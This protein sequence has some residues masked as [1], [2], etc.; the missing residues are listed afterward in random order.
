MFHLSQQCF[1]YS[2]C[3]DSSVVE[4]L[5][6]HHDNLVSSHCH[7]WLLL[8]VWAPHIYSSL[9]QKQASVRGGMLLLSQ[10]WCFML[11]RNEW[12]NKYLIWL[13]YCTNEGIWEDTGATQGPSI[14]CEDQA[15]NGKYLNTTDTKVGNVIKNLGGSKELK[16]TRNLLR[17]SWGKMFSTLASALV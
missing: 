15:K 14:S 7:G 9:K 4:R 8:R 1:I 3:R 11:K 16:L 2:I 12:K 17:I 6:R 13:L 5:V 10:S